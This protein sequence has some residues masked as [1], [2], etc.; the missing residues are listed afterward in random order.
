MSCCERGSVFENPKIGE[1]RTKNEYFDVRV[2]YNRRLVYGENVGEFGQE[3][4]SDFFSSVAED[5]LRSGPVE[6]GFFED[7]SRFDGVKLTHPD[8]PSGD[9]LVEI[10]LNGAKKRREAGEDWS[11][12][13]FELLAARDLRRKWKDC[14]EGSMFVWLYPGDE[15]GES[16]YLPTSIAYV[17]EVFGKPG[18]ERRVEGRFYKHGLNLEGNGELWR[19]LSGLDVDLGVGELISRSVDVSELRNVDS[20]EDVFRMI[21]KLSE[22][23]TWVS[24]GVV[25]SEGELSEEVFEV[26]KPQVKEAG[27]FLTM[28]FEMVYERSGNDLTQSDVDDLEVAYSFARRVVKSFYEGK[29]VVSAEQVYEDFLTR[30]R[31]AKVRPIGGEYDEGWVWQARAF[32]EQMR[33]RY[34]DLVSARVGGFDCPEGVLEGLGLN[35]GFGGLSSFGTMGYYDWG[36]YDFDYDVISQIT[37]SSKKDEMKCVVCPN[38]SCKKTVDA[39]VSSTHIECPKCHLKVRK[40]SAA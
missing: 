25:G 17:Y 3:L 2:V 29:E 24:E 35:V 31:Y 15:S 28:A 30:Q 7:E 9:D 19:G 39:I 22:D 33:Q 37:K 27:E 38:P 20:Y 23:P 36:G 4:V 1:L 6:L 11:R 21:D 10:T 14:D 5:V 12:Q 40:K 16:G 26:Y 8:Y 32:E 34:G 18:G 13:Y